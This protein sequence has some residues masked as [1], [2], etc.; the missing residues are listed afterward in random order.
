MTTTWAVEHGDKSAPG[1]EILRTVVG[2]GVH[3]LALEGQDDHDEMGVY[4][5]RVEDVVGV[6]E[7]GGHYVA[8][9]QP[10][11]ARSGPGDTDLVAYSLRK[12]LRLAAK[13]NPTVLLPLYAPDRDVLYTTDCGRALRVMADA[14]VS[15]QAGRRFLGYLDSQR[16]RLTGGGKRNRVPNRPELIAAHGY[17]TKFASHALRLGMQGV[18]LLTARRI[19]LPMP[20]EQ[21]EQVLEVKRGDVGFAVAL[22]RIDRVRTLLGELVDL[23]GLV[24]PEHADIDRINRFSA[25]W[26]LR[27]WPSPGNWAR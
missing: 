5:E 22:A 24:I 12:Y 1:Q 26:H 10:E 25:H 27:D 15:R 21:R 3:G 20:E 16:D 13:G 6:R 7:Q 18:E 2:S 8:R 9:T 23:S 17:D 14:F 4:I 19:T 11:G